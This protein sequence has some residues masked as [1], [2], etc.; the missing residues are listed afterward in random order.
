M[1]LPEG[2]AAPNRPASG[3]D[4]EGRPPTQHRPKIGL[5]ARAGG[6]GSGTGSG[7]GA[8]SGLSCHAVFWGTLQSPHPLK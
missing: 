4:C 6:T 5:Q 3:G 1:L 7:A 8:G 2:A